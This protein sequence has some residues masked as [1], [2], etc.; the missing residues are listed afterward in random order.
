MRAAELL[1]ER[2]TGVLYHYTGTAA[3]MKILRTGQFE[4][5][6][7]V[8]TKSESDYAPK[9]H[10]YF[11][12]LT[13]TTLGDYHRYVGT[14]GVLFKLNGDWFNSRY[15]VKPVDYWNGAWL[16]SDGTRT[17]ESEDRVFSRESSIPIAAITEVHV[18]LK[19]Q[20][21]FRSPYTRQIMILAKQQG[22]PVYL[23]TDEKSWRIT[24]K[25]NT[26]K[27]SQA[28]SLLKGKP[29]PGYSRKPTDYV[30]PWLELIEKDREEYLTDRAA[31]LLKTLLWYHYP[32]ND[33]NMSVDLSNARKPDSGDR[34][35]A[36]KLI[37]YM[38]DHGYKS[39]IDLKNDITEKWNN[40]MKAKN[41]SQ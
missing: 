16:H 33:Q 10:P 6:S 22:I 41:A 34:E 20:D 38:Q 14:G 7:V 37:K 36:V 30:K 25:R 26:L 28:K 27:P 17:R 11:L 23:Y 18:L 15:I 5:A 31:R 35:S 3:A 8:G 39:T 9:G 21:E 2:A 13:R 32:D 12:S 1:T 40:I 4:L 19:D 29:N 24:D